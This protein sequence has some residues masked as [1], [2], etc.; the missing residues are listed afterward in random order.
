MTPSVISC[1]LVLLPKLL[2]LAIK[3]DMLF[4]FSQFAKFYQQRGLNLHL[5]K[6]LS[7]CLDVQIQA[8]SMYHYAG[9]FIAVLMIQE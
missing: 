4:K 1:F 8:K 9:I 3:E 6:D 2:H 7:Y 5:L